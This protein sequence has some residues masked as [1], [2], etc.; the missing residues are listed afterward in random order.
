[1]VIKKE[2]GRT[3]IIIRKPLI[4]LMSPVY[5]TLAVILGSDTIV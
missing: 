5:L 4:K 2:I 3:N 1:M